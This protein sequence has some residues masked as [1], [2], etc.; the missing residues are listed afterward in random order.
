MTTTY[1]IKGMN[2]SHCQATV[3]KAIGS[4]AGVEEVDVDLKSGIA[5]VGGEHNA[6]EL[7]S[8]VRGAG[9]DVE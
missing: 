1:K 6:D 2:C 9:F 5:T 4:V 3:A 8:A 7:K